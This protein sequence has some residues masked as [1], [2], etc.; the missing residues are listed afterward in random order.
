MLNPN[1]PLTTKDILTSG[2]NMTYR[3]GGWTYRKKSLYPALQPLFDM[4]NLHR[5]TK[6]K[7]DMLQ[8]YL[9]MMM[10]DENWGDWTGLYGGMGSGPRDLEEFEDEFDEAYCIPAMGWP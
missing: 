2:R 9:R 7:L 10:K 8:S 3:E 1:A 5:N 4:V 6:R